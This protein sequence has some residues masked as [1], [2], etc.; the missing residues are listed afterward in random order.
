MPVRRKKDYVIFLSVYNLVRFGCIWMSCCVASLG[1]AQQR[2]AGLALSNE[3]GETFKR[4]KNGG[5]LRHVI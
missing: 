3:Q 2:Q 5:T 4:S 1:L